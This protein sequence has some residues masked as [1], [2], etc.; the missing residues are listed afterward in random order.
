MKINRPSQKQL[1]D[2]SLRRAWVNY[3]LA[4]RGLSLA[5]IA[6]REGV[7][8]TCPGQALRTP[9]PKME[10]AIADAVGMTVHELF[11][12]RFRSD[13]S[14]IQKKRGPRPK[15]STYKSSRNRARRNVDGR[16]ANEQKEAA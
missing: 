2:P 5:E 15:K 13:G 8:R 14:R 12:E 9:Y 7:H 11:P 10:R 1:R 6:R 3:A 16:G 4:M